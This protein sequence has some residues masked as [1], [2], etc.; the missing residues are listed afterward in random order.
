MNTLLAVIGL[1]LIG[2]VLIAGGGYWYWQSGRS[3]EAP[4]LLRR[5]WRR[6]GEDRDEK[7]AENGTG[8]DSG[9][10]S[11]G[12]VNHTST[13]ENIVYCQQCGN[14]A[15]PGDRFCRLCGVRLRIE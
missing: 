15:G 8:E 7:P 11:F 10:S 2:I 13:Q 1:I 5:Q 6:E 14:R 4:A 9:N 3:K 12:G